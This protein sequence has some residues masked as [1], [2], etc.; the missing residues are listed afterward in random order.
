M[1]EKL[2]LWARIQKGEFIISVQIDPPGPSVTA[3]AFETTIRKLMETGMEVVD[4]NSSRRVSHDSIELASV[5][6]R[7]GLETI[8]HV[9]TR[10]SSINGLVNQILAA[11][12]W[13]GLKN[14]LV[15]TGDPYEIEQAIVASTGVFQVD[16]IGAISKFHEHLRLKHDLPLTF[17]AAVNQNNQDLELERLR[18]RKKKE[19]GADFFMSQPVF[20]EWQARKLFEFYRQSFESPPPILMGIWPLINAKTIDVIYGGKITGVLMPEDLYLESLDFQ[21]SETALWTWGMKQVF[22][23]IGFI[24]ESGKANGVYIVAPS[25][26]PSQIQWLLEKLVNG[27]DGW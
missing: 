23:L 8:P 18:L 13:E 5:L 12:R 4:V 16:S 9:T 25:R 1:S 17:G 26:D 27:K 20:D 15:I 22:Q 14:F 19:A 3:A 2:D 24:R 6:A 10:D 21:N 11:H 7:K